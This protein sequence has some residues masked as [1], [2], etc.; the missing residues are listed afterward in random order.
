MFGVW[1]SRAVRHVRGGEVP[2]ELRGW[3]WEDPPVRPRA[4]LGLGV[5]E[6]V[7]RYCDSFR[8]VWLRRVA[9]VK[10]DGSRGGVAVGRL[11]HDVFHAA[12]SDLRELLLRGVDVWRAVQGLLEAGP[13]DG[14]PGW[15][16]VLYRRLVLVW[17]GEVEGVLLGGGSLW[18]IP[19]VTEILVNGSLVGLSPRLR[20]DALASGGVIVEVKVGRSRGDHDLV[21]AG[22]ALALESQLGVPFDYG[23]VIT[24]VGVPSGEP[25]FEV[26]GFFLGEM[27]RIRFLKYR[28]EAI[29][30]LLGGREPPLSSSCSRSCPF[31]EVCH[32]GDER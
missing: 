7:P 21:L 17:A 27:V 1:V 14:W 18:S 5:S 8:D 9:G 3:R 22:Y 29:D 23:V 16:A 19:W 20:V 30:V 26:R 15:A 24:V 10:G 11:V 31:Y 25:R 4:Y 12:A 32:G 6:I 13:R 28:D 2:G